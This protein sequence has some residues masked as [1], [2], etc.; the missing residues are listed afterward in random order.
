MIRRLT[1]TLRFLRVLLAARTVQD[2]LWGG[3]PGTRPVESWE[4]YLGACQKR[5]DRLRVIDRGN[6]SWRVE[7]RKRL[8]QLAALAVG[9]AEYLDYSNG[10]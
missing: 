4:S 10:R 3:A 8:L 6:G 7:T 1:Q 5:I 2:F 9:M